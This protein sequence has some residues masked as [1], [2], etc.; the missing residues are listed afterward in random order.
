MPVMISFVPSFV[1]SSNSCFGDRSLPAP[2]SSFAATPQTCGDA[3]EVPE[4]VRVEVAAPVQAAV[5]SEPGAA[6]SQQEP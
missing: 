2:L 5:M 4:M 3:M 1:I 6:M